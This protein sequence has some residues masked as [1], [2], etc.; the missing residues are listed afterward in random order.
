MS[1]ELKILDMKIL[2]LMAKALHV[3][4][5]EMNVVFEDGVQ[6]MR[7]NYYP[8][9][10][11]HELV[12]GLYPHSDSTALTILLQVNEIEGLQVKKDGVWIPVVPIPNAFVINI[13]DILEMVTNGIYRSIEH[14][15]T[16][17]P[18]KERLSIATFF[19]TNM[20][21]DIGP[22]PVLVTLKT[23][24]KFKTICFA[25]YLKGLFSR[26]LDGKSYL[27]SLRI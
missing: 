22:A 1:A 23:P 17:N 24:A 21:T 27:D 9:C 25:D 4:D 26:E 10:P 14:R 7:M 5:E 18:M 2:N 3:K 12:T 20:D 6:S 8:P 16:V 13:G 11:Q 19:S 15:A